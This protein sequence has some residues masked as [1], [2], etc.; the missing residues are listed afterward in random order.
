MLTQLATLKSRLGIADTDVTSDDLLTSIIEAIS[1]RFDR[2]CNR[3]FARAEDTTFEFDG[4][5]REISPP[6][7]PIESV[8]KFE[9]KVSEAA[10]WV[11]QTGVDYL[12]RTACTISLSESINSQ[13]ST[14]NPAL[15]RITYTGGYVL[16][17]TDPAPGQ[18]PLPPDLEHACIE[19]CAAWFLTRDKVGLEINW[20]KGGIYQRFSQLP[21]LPQVQSILLRHQR[22]TI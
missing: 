12:I 11:E 6:S 7:Y 18:T 2:E 10:G 20:P 19:Q 8:S 22:L 21:L 17:G 4:D 13:P 16:P 5:R 9:T 14:I 1:A 15:A 3:T